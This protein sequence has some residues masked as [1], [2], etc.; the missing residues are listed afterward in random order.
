[1]S[2]SQGRRKHE[3]L[4]SALDDGNCLV[5][6]AAHRHVRRRLAAVARAEPRW[7]LA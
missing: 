7:R 3:A 4:K 2:D 5:P 1:M 6:V